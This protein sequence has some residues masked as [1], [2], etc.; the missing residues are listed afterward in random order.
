MEKTTETK[1][2]TPRVKLTALDK[3]FATGHA[4]SYWRSKADAKRREASLARK[5]HDIAPNAKPNFVL[6]LETLARGFD[7]YAAF[8]ARVARKAKTKAFIAQFEREGGA[9]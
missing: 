5:R 4:P 1:P 6:A 9:L 8:A 3:R 2:R 7:A